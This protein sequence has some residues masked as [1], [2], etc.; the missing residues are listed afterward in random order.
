MMLGTAGF[1]ALLCSFAVKAKR[2]FY[3]E[4]KVKD[5]LVT[6]ATGG[7][8]SIAVMILSKMGYHVH[9]VTGKKDKTD[10]LRDLGAKNIIDR[11]E[12]ER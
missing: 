4:K 5:V 12:F 7:V 11:K 2:N 1:T 3:W 6:G 9:A 8:G 10:Y